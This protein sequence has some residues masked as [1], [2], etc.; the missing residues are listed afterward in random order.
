MSHEKN[1]RTA[2]EMKSII[3]H[4]KSFNH[5]PAQDFLFHFRFMIQTQKQ[6]LIFKSNK[7]NQIL[8]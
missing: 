1:E 4:L 8:D 7:Q 3:N 5:P 2:H 6:F